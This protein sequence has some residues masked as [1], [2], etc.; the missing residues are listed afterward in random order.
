MQTQS[1]NFPKPRNLLIYPKQVYKNIA[2]DKHVTAFG[3]LGLTGE[4]RGVTQAEKR[5]V[6][7]IKLGFKKIIIP[8]YNYN[9]VKKYADKIEI[10]AVSYLSQAI[11]HLFSDANTNEVPI[12]D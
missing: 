6:D 4:V 7:S 3:E 2:I 11:K 5:V 12:K 9:A 10:V 8:K 1:W